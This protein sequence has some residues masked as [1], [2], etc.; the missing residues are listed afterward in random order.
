MPAEFDVSSLPGEWRGVIG[1]DRATE[2]EEELMREVPADH[3]LAGMKVEAV[4]FNKNQKDVVFWL[5]E[6]SQWALVHLTG[7]AESDPQWPSTEFADD[8]TGIAYWLG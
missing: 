1:D 8:W 6:R 2:L 4:A 7:R 3:P 5:P